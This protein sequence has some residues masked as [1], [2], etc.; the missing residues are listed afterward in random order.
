M[1]KNGCQELQQTLENVGHSIAI[2]VR[3]GL[4][5][6]E[7]IRR[8]SKMDLLSEDSGQNWINSGKFKITL[9][10][11]ILERDSRKKKQTETRLS[12]RLFSQRLMFDY[13]QLITSAD[14]VANLKTLVLLLSSVHRPK[15]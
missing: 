9:T 7:P 8:S 1:I 2:L 12:G 3:N 10:K 6:N 13:R 11:Y 5:P 14:E 4:V 15:V